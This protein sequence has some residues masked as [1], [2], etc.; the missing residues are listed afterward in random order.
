MQKP[1]WLLFVK[2]ELSVTF[3]TS[4]QYTWQSRVLL[5]IGSSG[6]GQYNLT[7]WV[8]DSFGIGTIFINFQSEV[9]LPV[10][11]KLNSEAIEGTIYVG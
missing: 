10:Y 9:S 6:M 4:I 2:A 11:D 7:P 1:Y 8:W 5:M 3:L